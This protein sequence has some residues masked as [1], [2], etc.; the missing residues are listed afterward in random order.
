M[1]PEPRQP[2]IFSVVKRYSKTKLILSILSPASSFLVVAI[3]LVSGFSTSLRDWA[4]SQSSNE[5]VVV[6]IVLFAITLI[7]SAVTFPISFY[8][9]YIIE[10]RYNLS[11]QTAWGWLWERLKGLLI[12]T[13]L[14]VAGVVVLF[15]CLKEYREWWWLPVSTAL[16]FFS[17]VFA[18]VVPIIIMPLFY[19]FTPLEDHSLKEAIAKLCSNAGIRFDG[20]FSFNMSKNTKKANAGF[21]GIGRSKR[22]ILGDTLLKNFSQEEIETDYQGCGNVLF[23]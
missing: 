18:R 23:D 4:T 9:S 7:E 20:I 10:H 5:Y 13:P 2:E 22:I 3:I 1:S 21:T 11:N 19:K 14:L 12:G 6:L 8:S 17:V 15:Y 16:A